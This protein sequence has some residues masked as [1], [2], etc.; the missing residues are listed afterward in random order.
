MKINCK[1]CCKDLGEILTG[2]KL[3]KGIVY[4]CSECMDE[5]NTYESIADFKRTTSTPNNDMDAVKDMFGDIF[6][7]KK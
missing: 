7:G 4:L 6:K 5:Y 2:S 1:K 3:R